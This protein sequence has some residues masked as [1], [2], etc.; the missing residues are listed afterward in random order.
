M[1]QPNT[2][3]SERANAGLDSMF[4]KYN[5][6]WLALGLRAGVAIVLGLTMFLMPGI[7]LASIVILF[8]VYATA[9]G[10]FAIVASIRG[11]RR[12]ERWGWML[13]EGIFGVAAGVIALLWP[14]IGAMALTLL[15]AGWA[16]ATG[17]LE[18]AAAVRLRKIMRGEWLLMVAGILSIILALLIAFRPTMGAVV[19]IW[20]LGAYLLAYGALA[21]AFAIK[22][23]RW[24]ATHR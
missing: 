12:K 16:L 5:G 10:I 9:D 13:V 18:V 19:L 22:V 24:T 4:E 3:E 8:G 2:A 23:R 21:L 14:G 15:V 20:W 6:N 17:A 7:A 11:I 1:T